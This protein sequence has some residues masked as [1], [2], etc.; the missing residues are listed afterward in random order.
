M[1]IVAGVMPVVVSGTGL[2]ELEQVAPGGNPVQL[3]VTLL[4]PAVL[5][6][7]LKA[8]VVL[9]PAAMVALVGVP[10]WIAKVKSLAVPPPDFETTVIMIGT[11]SEVLPAVSVQVAP[12][13]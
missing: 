2:G 12:K 7:R 5:C 1:V 8:K 4:V 10:D 11:A 3:N 9:A 13:L 6:C